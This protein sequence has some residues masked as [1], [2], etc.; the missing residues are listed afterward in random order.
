MSKMPL[1][2]MNFEGIIGDVLKIPAFD[3]NAWIGLYLKNGVVENM[4]RLLNKFQVVIVTSQETKVVSILA[5]FKSN[6][7]VFDGV[8][9]RKNQ[10][11]TN[12]LFSSYMHIYEDFG[13]PLENIKWN[14]LLLCPIL[15]ENAEIKARNNE[16]LVCDT[17][18]SWLDEIPDCKEN[19]PKAPE[20]KS[21]TQQF[22]IKHLN[23][24]GDKLDSPVTVLVPHFL[25]QID[26]KSIWFSNVVTFIESLYI[27]SATNDN[28]KIGSPVRKKSN[29]TV[30]ER[31]YSKEE[32]ESESKPN[33][34]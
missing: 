14:T 19:L 3:P 17:L 18:Y 10:E 16:Q 12:E 11:D 28:D 32:M 13:I 15:L 27:A 8:Y 29:F 24:P 30:I 26:N 34:L 20:R 25:S 6:G 33:F 23:T 21:K 5:Y 31:Q 1:V 7:I 9:L 22:H 4:K 2:I